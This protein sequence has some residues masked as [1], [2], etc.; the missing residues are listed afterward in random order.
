MTVTLGRLAPVPL[1]DVWPH[2]ANDFTP[3]LA[4]ADNLA[5]LA[6]TLGLGDLQIQGTEVS[7]GNFYLDILARD[8]AGNVVVIENQFGLT[9]HVHLGQ[10]MTYIA[11]QE[12]KVTIVWIAE[13]FREEHRAAVDWLNASTIDGFD[14]FAVEVEALKIGNSSPAPRFNVIGKPNEWS[15]D[16]TRTTRSGERPLDERQ[17]GYVAYWT[18]LRAFLADRHAP[19]K[20]SG[21]TPRDYSCSFGNIGQSG[22]LLAATAGFRDRKLGVEIYITHRA[23]KLAFD[24]LE[25]ERPNIEAEFGDRL[26]WQRLNDKKASR[27]AIY[28]TDLDPSN[29]GQWPLQHAWFLEQL[30]RFVRVFQGRI[31]AFDIDA[32]EQVSG[33]GTVSSQ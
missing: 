22:F 9:D 13:E 8:R 26:D 7:V 3:W 30:D 2:E 4:Q 5:L 20:V 1:R 23:A 17:K 29:Q 27:I 19:F 21:A 6:E 28:R 14:F 33:T 31:V 25:A 10:I 32:L 15:R 12:G 18:A 11:G 24:H 16:V